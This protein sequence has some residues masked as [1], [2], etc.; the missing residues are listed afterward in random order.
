MRIPQ[1]VLGEKLQ[2]IASVCKILHRLWQMIGRTES[3][4]PQRNAKFSPRFLEGIPPN[5][6]IW[7]LL[8]ILSRRAI[9]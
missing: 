7:R 4:N 9:D 5:R 8:A 2:G 3:A 6:W 1:D